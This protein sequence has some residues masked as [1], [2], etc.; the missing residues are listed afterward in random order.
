MEILKIVWG[1][2][3]FKWDTPLYSHLFIYFFSVAILGWPLVWMFCL[4]D[5]SSSHM[6]MFYSFSVNMFVQTFCGFISPTTLLHLCLSVWSKIS[7]ISF[8]KDKQRE[9]FKSFQD[10][11]L[12]YK[13]ASQIKVMIIIRDLKCTL[14]WS[15][16]PSFLYVLD[17]LWP[18]GLVLVVVDLVVITW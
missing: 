16:L 3:R 17:C 9:G 7:K 5:Q 6:F 8:K 2:N 14:N 10:L 15:Y 18:R 13:F 4:D 11:V 12:I 1:R